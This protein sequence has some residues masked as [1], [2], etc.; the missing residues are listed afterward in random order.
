[1]KIA[2]VAAALLLVV[3]AELAAGPS[4]PEVVGDAL[5]GAALVAGGGIAAARR[6]S[7]VVGLLLLAAGAA[8]LA[9]L[10]GGSLA[11]LHRGPLVHAVLLGARRRRP[12]VAAI[13]AAYVTGA[14]SEL[15][16]LDAV[17]LGMGVLVAVAAP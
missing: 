9:G 17:T 7:R 4:W 10:A 11:A 3:A 16:V 8:W 15:A 2:T 1:M 6:S 5:A 13:M 14:V 12:A